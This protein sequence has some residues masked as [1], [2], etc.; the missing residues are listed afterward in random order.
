MRYKE[1]SR[2]GVLEKCIP[3]F[4][5]NGFRACAI[6]D[7]VETTKVNRFSLYDEFGNKEGILFASLQLYRDRYS[8]KNFGI[9]GKE[10]LIDVILSEFYLSFFNGD[11]FQDGCY[12]I[13]VGM[14]LADE[15]EDIRDFL[16]NYIDEIEILFTQL[17]NR[18]PETN[19]NS[20]FYARN[21]IG[22]FCTSMS[23]CLIH[24]DQ[25]R[26]YHINNGIH[27]ILNKNAY[28]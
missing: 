25:E 21:L 15:D 1:F 26:V 4:W 7:I 22:L 3:L 10:G 18:D 19:S 24:S 13:H 12:V 28:A 17:L 11:K 14:E 20:G 2:N 5:R 16:K 6:S 23:F 8:S 27:L 9:L